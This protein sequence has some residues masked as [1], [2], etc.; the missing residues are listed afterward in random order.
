MTPEASPTLVFDR[1]PAVTPKLPPLPTGNP[2]VWIRRPVPGWYPG[3]WPL[4]PTDEH[5][6]LSMPYASL[7]CPARTAPASSLRMKASRG[8]HN[9]RDAKAHT[10]NNL[11]AMNCPVEMA[12]TPHTSKSKK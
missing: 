2:Q 8:T 6:S 4:A 5:V 1:A 10:S 12:T 3:K 7:P 9:R 11:S